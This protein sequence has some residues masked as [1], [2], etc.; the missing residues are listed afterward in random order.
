[1][2]EFNGTPHNTAKKGQIAK[3]VLMPGDPLRAKFIAETFLENPVQFNAVRGILGFTGR[4]KGVEISVM[5]S[6]IGMPSMGLYSYEL[7]KF[8]DVENIIRIGSAGA[9]TE[10]LDLFDIVVADSVFS[11]STYAKTQCGYDKDT[12]QPSEKINDAIEQSAAELGKKVVKGL[13]HSCD[14]FYSETPYN[15]YEDNGALCVEMESF[16]LLSN[17]RVLGKN[18]ACM[19]TVSDHLVTHKE[20]TTQERQ[21]AF[22]DMM[23]IALNAAIRL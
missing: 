9:Y 19:F 14:V 22:T 6:G 17:A 3:T 4:Y 13:V 2:K 12:I 7:F 11:E 20:T 15:P 1:M 23:E 8:Y 10:K 18:A 16:A 5:A 21:T